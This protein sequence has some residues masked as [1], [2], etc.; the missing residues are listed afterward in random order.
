MSQPLTGKRVAILVTDGFEQAELTGP[1]EALENAGARAD[2]VA[3]KNGEVT[4]WNH[5]TPAT[6]FHVDQ[7]FDAIRIADYDAVLLPGGV[8]NSDTIRTEATA[9]RLVREAAQAGKPI[10]VICHG[11]WLLISAGLVNGRRMTS[12]PSLADDLRNAG[13]EW[14]DEPVVIDG[15]LISSRKPDDIPAFSSALIEALQSA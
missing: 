4:G 14:V 12:W 2:I 10:A 3:P 8:V 7:T 15:G 1:R 5:T 13:A 6:K 9:Q 11:S